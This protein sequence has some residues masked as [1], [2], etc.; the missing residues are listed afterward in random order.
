VLL[1]VCGAVRHPS[2]ANTNGSV[3]G[4]RTNW[5]VVIEFP[6]DPFHVWSHHPGLS[7]SRFTAE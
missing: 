4:R 3:E 5:V 7:R 2:R 1:C 6:V